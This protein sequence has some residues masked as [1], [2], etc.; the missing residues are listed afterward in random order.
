MV[1]RIHSARTSNLHS[2]ASL[3]TP[4]Y[5]LRPHIRYSVF[6]IIGIIENTL[7]KKRFPLTVIGDSS[8]SVHHLFLKWH[9][10]SETLAIV[11]P[12]DNQIGP[13]D[14]KGHRSAALDT[15]VVC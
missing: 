10:A 5:L 9:S 1:R 7:G 8:F 3:S 4:T 14:K 6:S 12:S 2:S 11:G 15:D 13:R